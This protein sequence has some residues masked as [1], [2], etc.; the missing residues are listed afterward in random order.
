[1]ALETAAFSRRVSPFT[2]LECR[3]SDS[4]ST[5]CRAVDYDSPHSHRERAA[6]AC[7][8]TVP[9]VPKRGVP[10]LTP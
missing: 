9:L 4:R 5:P 1:M 6:K 3:A 7:G 10:F 8:V 2:G